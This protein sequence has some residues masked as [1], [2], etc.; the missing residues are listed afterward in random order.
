MIQNI[1]HFT[2]GLNPDFGKKEFCLVHFLAIK[3]AYYVNRP[4]KIY[5]HYCYEPHGYWWEMAKKYVELSKITPF[6]KIFGHKL[7]NVAHK[8]DIVRLQ[9]LIDVGGIYLDIDTICIK[10]FT[11]LLHHSF[12]MGQEGNY[13]LCNAVMLSCR[14]A[15]FPKAMLD[16]YKNFRSK[17]FDEYWNE[18]S[19]R[20]PLQLSKKKQ[21]KDH[22]HIEPE[23]SFFFP[24]FH[25]KHLDILFLK[26]Y[27]FE[28]AYCYH[29]WESRSYER[30]IQISKIFQPVADEF[31][32]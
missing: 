14:N 16:T 21:F 20:I 29:L 3:S 2:Y 11:P 30:H 26:N 19:V 17:G 6:D 13:G 32:G 27:K 18:H 7:Y 15:S 4:K 12:V 22:I 1:I 9:K 31:P 10:P 23:E 28:R 25:P 24:S 8:S 5:M